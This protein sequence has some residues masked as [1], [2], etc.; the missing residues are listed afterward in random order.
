MKSLDEGRAFP[1][2]GAVLPQTA[3]GLTGAIA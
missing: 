3:R 1:P 2:R